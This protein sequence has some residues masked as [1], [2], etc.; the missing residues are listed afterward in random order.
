M[1]NLDNIQLVLFDFDDT[2]CIHKDHRSSEVKDLQYNINV[3]RIGADTW[4][5]CDTNPHM[6]LFMDICADK[7]IRMGLISATMGY[8]HSQAKH[9]WV[10]SK[11]GIDLENYCVGTFEN[12]LKI[13]QAISLAFDI[14][15]NRILIVDDLYENLVRAANDGFQACNP[16]EVVNYITTVVTTPDFEPSEEAE[17]ELYAPFEDWE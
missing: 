8:I 11:Y 12:K 13:M 15:K 16:M 14:P 17:Y 7:Y 4:N 2:L 10:L 9:D 5:D 3:L 6:K 1:I